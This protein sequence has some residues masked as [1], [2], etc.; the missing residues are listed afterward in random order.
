M[1]KVKLFYIH[2]YSG[3][4]SM[5]TLS[6][7]CAARRHTSVYSEKILYLFRIKMSIYIY[8]CYC[9]LISLSVG[10]TLVYFLLIILVSKILNLLSSANHLS[11]LTL[12]LDVYS[13]TIFGQFAILTIT[14]LSE[15]PRVSYCWSHIIFI[16]QHIVSATFHRIF[17][18]IRLIKTDYP[19]CLCAAI[20]DITYI[21]NCSKFIS[22]MS[23]WYSL[24]YLFIYLSC[25]HC[26]VS[27]AYPRRLRVRLY[28]YFIS[29]LFSQKHTYRLSEFI[30]KALLMLLL[31]AGDIHLNPGPT[32]DLCDITLC[33]INVRSFNSDKLRTINRYNSGFRYDFPIRDILWNN[34]PDNDLI[35]PGYHN[36]IRKDLP[37]QVG[38]V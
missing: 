8:T 17:T 5:I 31:L 34:T 3:T 14:V 13:C 37:N 36:I 7:L 9:V 30:S 28:L 20:Q 4:L 23:Q 25:L 1:N 10:S 38:A 22:S 6:S 21:S 15:K 11:C 16:S 26:L 33:H 19:Y 35:L 2:F 29:I 27:I 18:C 24:F 12:S 32:G